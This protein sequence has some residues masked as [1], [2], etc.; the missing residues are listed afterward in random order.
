MKF[1]LLVLFTVGGLIS[2]HVALAQDVSP[3]VLLLNSY[4]PQYSW[5]SQLQAGVAQ[6]LAERMPPENLHVEFMDSRRFVGDEIHSTMLAELLTHKY[7]QLKPDVVLTSD[8]A[9]FYFMLKH[10][11]TLF[12]D[13]PVGFMGVN[14]LRPEALTNNE[15]MFGILEGMAIEAN[16]QLI[17][18]MLPDVEQIVLLADDTVFGRKM[19]SRALEVKSS[20]SALPGWQ[21]IAID[22]WND[23][24]KQELLTNVGKLSEKSAILMLAIHKDNQGYYFSFAEDLPKLVDKSAVRCLVCGEAAYCSAKGLWVA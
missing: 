3:R 24:S 19:V 1:V 10:G 13:V 21:H 12:P 22:I 8:D 20:L 4:H 6:Q 5:T 15:N 11:A 9:A 23:F 16:L 7:Q 17:A 2:P 18:S 14:V